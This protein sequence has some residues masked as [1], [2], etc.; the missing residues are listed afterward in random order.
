MVDLDDLPA[1]QAEIRR[2]EEQLGESG[3]TITA[4]GLPPTSKCIDTLAEN[5][6]DR[7]VLGLN[8]ENKDTVFES[9]Q[10]HADATAAYRS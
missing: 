6:V 7:M 10:A 5:Q 2:L 9:L 1:M 8:F 4:T 3:T